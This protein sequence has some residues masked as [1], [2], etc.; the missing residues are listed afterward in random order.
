MH[1]CLE[2]IRRRQRIEI[3]ILTSTGGGYALDTCLE[4]RHS[5]VGTADLETEDLLGVL[6]LK[7]D[8]VPELFAEDGRVDEVGPLDDVWGFFKPFI[9][10]GDHL[11]VVGFISGD[12]MVWK[13]TPDGGVWGLGQVFDEHDL[14][15]R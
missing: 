3:H 4:N 13:A 11:F 8:V 1:G 9:G 7:V 12:V 10:F 6:A 5:I 14:K 15:T 2:C